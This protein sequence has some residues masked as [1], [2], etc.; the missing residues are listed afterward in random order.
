MPFELQENAF[1]LMIELYFL[2]LMVVTIQFFKV[3]ENR[4]NSTCFELAG[5]PNSRE[6]D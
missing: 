5:V 3:V 4:C 2:Q 6:K 1:N